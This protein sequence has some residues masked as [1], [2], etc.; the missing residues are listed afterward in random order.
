MTRDEYDA[1]LSQAKVDGA[2]ALMRCVWM[3]QDSLF[4]ALKQLHIATLHAKPELLGP[5]VSYTKASFFFMETKAATSARGIR[6][7][8][9]F[10]KASGVKG[11]MPRGCKSEAA[12]RSYSV[13]QMGNTN[14]RDGRSR[15]E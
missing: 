10:L 1:E 2:L 13:A 9:R 7:R 4:E 11:Y 15:A 6:F 12:R 8:D 3:G 5:L 14:R